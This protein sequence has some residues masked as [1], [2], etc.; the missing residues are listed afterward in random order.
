MI[1]LAH[2]IN[3]VNAPAGSEL[4]RVQP[5]TFESIRRAKAFT[6][7]EAQV[8][9]YTVSYFEDRAIIPDFFTP[10][11]D[12][13][14]SVLDL[15]TFGKKKKL[16]FIKD[17]LTSLYDHTDSDWLIYTNADICLMPQFYSAVAAEIAEG[18]DAILITR[19]RVSKKYDDVA[20][21]PIL[22]SEI[23]GYHP[24]YDCFVFHRSLL[25]KFVLDDICIGVPFIEVTLLHN[26]IAYASSLRH[27]DHLHLTFHI[28]MEVM[29][30]IDQEYYRYNRSIYEKNILPKL[31]PLLDINKFPYAEQPL[32]RRMVRRMLNPCISTAMALELE[33]KSFGRKIK[34]LADELR[35]KIIS[36]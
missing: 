33:G 6:G 27:I 28:G 8:E 19:R 23:G 5:V 29:P 7:M 31:R 12:L 2:I 4:A 14:R 10:L 30:P 24:G 35:W 15:G 22:Y 18:H 16:P 1:K 13:V 34:I 17:I 3:P 36:G 25:H 21:L 26:F 32:W 11:P 9:L 20:H